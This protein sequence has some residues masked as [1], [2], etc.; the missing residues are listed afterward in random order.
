MIQDFKSNQGHSHDWVGRVLVCKC[1]FI[2][3]QTCC[4]KSAA[5]AEDVDG[6][7]TEAA[8]GLDAHDGLHALVEDGVAGVARSLCVRRHLCQDVA[9]GV[10]G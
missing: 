9:H 3:S 5:P 8:R 7:H 10:A 4:E 1:S 2:F 6:E